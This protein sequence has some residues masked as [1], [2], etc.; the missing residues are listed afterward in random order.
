MMTYGN[1]T[2]GVITSFETGIDRTLTPCFLEAGI[3]KHSSSIQVF[4]LT[5][6][7]QLIMVL[8]NK[9]VPA[10]QDPAEV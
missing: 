2:R 1:C 9:A 3:F 6:G 8:H 10:N 4:F 5:N 7:W